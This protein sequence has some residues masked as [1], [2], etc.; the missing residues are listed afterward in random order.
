MSGAFLRHFRCGSLDLPMHSI[1]DVLAS[2]ARLSWQ[3]CVAAIQEIVAQLAPGQPVP[4]FEDILL[5]PDGSISFGFAGESKRSQVA[6]VGTLLVQLLKKTDGPPAPLRELAEENSRDQPAHTTIEG[7]SR[8][9]AFYERP[10]RR[11]DLQALAGRLAATGQGRRPVDIVTELRQKVTANAVAQ[12]SKPAV[13]GDASA[14]WRLAARWQL[15]PAVLI[16]LG[17]AAALLLA[18]VGATAMLRAKPSGAQPVAP[19]TDREAAI[20]TPRAT[21]GPAERN[22]GAPRSAARPAAARELKNT[23]TKGTAA[24]TRPTMDTPRL[25]RVASG[26]TQRAPGVLL[27]PVP[28]IKTGAP[29]ARGV[30]HG[31]P[32][33]GPS[34]GDVAPVDDGSVYS[35]ADAE[36]RPPTWLRQQLP[37]HPAPDRQTGYFDIIVDTQGFVEALR[38]VSPTHRYEERMLMAAAKAWKFRPAE[39]NGRPVKYRLRVP[40]TLPPPND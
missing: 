14:R 27:S 36:V 19:A 37:S 12:A 21:S 26:S 28:A 31:Q 32:A 11:S 38:L 9:L 35:A 23:G 18:V 1:S 39:I 4:A 33:P 25:S 20:E 15:T 2:D 3:E 34:S 40:I 10:N 8:A 7:F 17:V 6:D 24:S 29:P 16:S 13:S 22:D 5:E 30:S